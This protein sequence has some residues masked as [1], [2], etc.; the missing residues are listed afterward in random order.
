MDYTSQVETNILDAFEGKTV[1]YVVIPGLGEESDFEGLGLANKIALIKRGTLNFDENAASAAAKG[2]VTAI[3]HNNGDDGL[4]YAALQTHSIPVITIAKDGAEQ[5][6]AAQDKHIHFSAEYYG[7]ATNPAGGQL[8]EED[9]KVYLTCLARDNVYNRNLTSVL[10][11]DGVTTIGESAFW[12]C[13]GI[14]SIQLPDSV[15]RIDTYGL[16]GVNAPLSIPQNLKWIGDEAFTQVPLTK[17]VLPEGQTHIGNK[18]FNNCRSLVTASISES[19]TEYGSNIFLYCTDL[20]Y[21]GLPGSLTE[22]PENMLWGTTALKRIQIPEGVTKIGIGASY[23][24]GIEK[25]TI[26]SSVKEIGDWAFAW[27]TDMREITTPDTVERIGFSAYIYSGGVETVNIGSGVKRI[28]MDA[29]HT[30]NMD[31]DEPPVMNVK[32]EEAATALRRSGYGQKILLEGAPYT[33]YNGVQFTDC[34]FSY[35]PLGHRSAGGWL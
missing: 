2:A 27:L 20:T 5:M 34:M 1:E 12:F 11:P 32:T 21:V 15:E 28:G 19:V 29:F 26:S 31:L 25:L 35:M 18:A 4:Y 22:I 16:Y 14:T 30:W 8:Y 6:I 9:G 10:I 13:S 17:A 3:I 7:V 33:G 24:S 23:G